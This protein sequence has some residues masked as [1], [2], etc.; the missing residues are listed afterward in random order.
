MKLLLLGKDGQVGWELQRALAPL[1]HLVAYG[2]HEI[3]LL[4]IEALRAAIRREAPDV[5]V[6]AA[7]YTAVDAAESDAATATAINATAVHAM[8]QEAA[9]LGA[10]LVHYS[11]DYVF[12]GT[13]PGPYVENDTIGAQ[14]VYGRTKAE[15]EQAIRASGCRH[16]ILRTSW[17]YAARGANFAKTMLRLASQRDE[18]R[19][20]AD[21]TGAPTSAA[22]IADVTALCLYRLGCDAKLADTASGTYHLAAHQHT[23][24]HGYAQ[25]VITRAIELGVPL[26]ATAQS[27]HPISTQDYPVPAVRPANSR[28]DTHKLRS[29]FGIVLPH[30]QYHVARLVAE[31]ADTKQAAS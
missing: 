17:V 24:W 9:E 2:R 4:N 1:G 18:L 20:V 19:V 11:T 6:N 3:D 14:N 22:L 27:V 23:T 16:L 29:T 15:G 30:W 21:Q 28:L 7:A 25:F 13:K 8:A 5:V 31:I 10:W 12:D 26:R